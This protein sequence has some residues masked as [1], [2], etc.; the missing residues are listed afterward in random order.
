MGCVQTMIGLLFAILITGFC[1]AAPKKFDSTGGGFVPSPEV[2]FIQPGVGDQLAME[3]QDPTKA[4]SVADS[5]NASRYERSEPGIDERTKDPKFGFLTY[6]TTGLQQGYSGTNGLTSGALKL[7]IGGVVLGALI[8]LGAV[9]LIPKILHLL[10]EK[11]QHDSYSGY[12]GYGRSENAPGN[13]I[14]S[15]DVMKV[16][17]RV[18]EALSKNNIDSSSCMQRAVCSYMKSVSSKVAEGSASS[19]DTVIDNVASN[20][21]LSFM[22][23]GTS[24]KQAV[25]KGKQG[26]NCSANFSKCPFNKETVYVALKSVLAE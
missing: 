5:F 26:G 1:Q 12:S 24:I 17:S 3:S 21:V 14:S 2:R 8:G 6:G 18:D 10:S 13:S 20:A 9:V 23:D 22:L 15:T 25:D 11:P 19:V 16:L 4:A 7:D